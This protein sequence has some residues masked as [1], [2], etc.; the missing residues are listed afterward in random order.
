MC[1]IEYIS[2]YSSVSFSIPN[3]SS[4]LSISVVMPSS[5]GALPVC[6]LFS[7][8]L[9]SDWIIGGPSLFVGTGSAGLASANR[10]PTYSAHLFRTSSFS[11]IIFPCLLQKAAIRIEDELS[12]YIAIRRG[13]RQGCVLSPYLFNIYTEFIF[14]EVEQ[15]GININ[16]KNINNIRYADDTAL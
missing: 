16:G 5:P 9:T 2:L 3:S 6:E 4:C 11:K 1:P 10:S 15:E 13:V 7:A 8:F 12:P 14:R